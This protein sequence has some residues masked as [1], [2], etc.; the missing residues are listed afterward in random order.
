[1][2][3]ICI[4]V[5]IYLM[6]GK[7]AEKL[8]EKIKDVDWNGRLEELKTQLKPYAIK[9]GRKASRPLL[10]FYYVM[11]D[12]ETTTM[13]KAMIYGAIIYVIS[14]VNLLPRA[15]YGLLGMTDEAAAMV[16][17]YKKIKNKITPAINSKVD[18]TLR[19]WFGDEYEIVRRQAD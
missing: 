10:Q 19:E 4:M 5:L 15:V 16:F 6:S 8:M 17:V 1:M 18:D 14:P 13:E 9:Y 7:N 11:Q 2:T 3:V 12:A